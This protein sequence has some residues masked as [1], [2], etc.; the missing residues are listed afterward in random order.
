[1]SAVLPLGHAVR[2]ARNNY[3]SQSSHAATLPKLTYVA[4]IGIASPKS[5]DPRNP[6]RNGIVSPKS[7]FGIGA[8]PELEFQVFDTDRRLGQNPEA[9]AIKTFISQLSRSVRC[10][11]KSSDPVRISLF[12]DIMIHGRV[13][14]A[15]SSRGRRS[16]I[17][18]VRGII[19][20]TDLAIGNFELPICPDA[21]TPK[22]MLFSP[23]EAAE[24]VSDFGFDA[25]S[26]ATNH[27]WDHGR[28]TVE[29]TLA[30]VKSSGLEVFGLGDKTGSL[31]RPIVINKAGVRIGLVGY[32][33]ASTI[34][35]LRCYTGAAPS[36]RLIQEDCSGLREKCNAIVISVHGGSG[37]CPEPELRKWARTALDNGAVAYVVHHAHR[38]SGF[39]EIGDGVAAYGLGNLT[40][41][42]GRHGMCIRLDVDGGG[43]SD[44]SYELFGIDQWGLPVP[45]DQNQREELE[46]IVSRINSILARDDY[47]SYYWRM[48][49]DTDRRSN[50]F[51]SLRRDLKTHGWRIMLSRFR[52]LRP[53]HLRLMWHLLTKR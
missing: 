47:E 24:I 18:Q 7:E 4:T 23:P 14:E 12:G 51:R 2:H 25:V 3:S 8:S 32:A 15:I 1:L 53:H 50:S 29:N 6:N 13:L 44:W 39:E 42:S 35:K 41:Q 9:V 38:I 22:N 46:Q 11:M 33:T 16:V 19:G 40:G 17:D 45:G 34:T 49:P 43:V 21:V 27:M 48:L 10:P 26:L 28:E 36:R 5:R 37:G 30:L 31:P 52:R 20:D